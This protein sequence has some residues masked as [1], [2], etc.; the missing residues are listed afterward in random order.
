M[1]FTTIPAMTDTLTLDTFA[2]RLASHAAID[3]ILFMGSTG[4]GALNAASDYDLLVILA[5]DPAAPRM[6]VTWVD[7]HFTELYC[8]P[9]T[10]LARIVAEPSAWRE[11]SDEGAVIRW[12]RDGRIFHDRAGRLADAQAVARAAPPLM[13]VAPKGPYWAWGTLG[14]NVAQAKRYLA[15]DDPVYQEVVGFRLLYGLAEVMTAYFTVRGLPWRGEKEAIVYWT[16]HDPAYLAQFRACLAETDRGR[17]V[18]RYEELARLTLAPVGEL[19]ARG[20]AMVGAGTGWGAGPDSLQ[21]SIEAAIEEANAFWQAMVAS[22]N[23]E[24]I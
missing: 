2:A 17:K 12:L 9:I 23:S 7:G 3:G 18:A 6:V 20:T 10:A 15:S 16:A 19:W 13:V 24:E 5:D 4:S 8:T 22:R 21:G 1:S 11:G 14:Y